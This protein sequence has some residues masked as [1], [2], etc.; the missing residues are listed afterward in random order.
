MVS[1]L[2]ATT[3]LWAGAATLAAAAGS[4]TLV[5]TF[6]LTARVFDNGGAV[7]TSSVLSVIVD[8]PA[9]SGGGTQTTLAHSVYRGDYG[10]MAE[11][12]RFA[13]AVNRNNRATFIGYSSAPTG[14][15]Y[16][17]TD[18]AINPD[19]TFTVRDANNQ[20]VLTGQTSPTGVSGSSLRWGTC[21]GK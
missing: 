14:R 7:T 3:G 4:T 6:E 16:F 9:P 20:V 17:W 11:S 1:A 8:P 5:G 21:G 19:G 13:F 10:S 12:G 2:A 15:T 18:I